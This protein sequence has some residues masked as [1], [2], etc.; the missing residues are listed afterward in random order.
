MRRCSKI[1]GMMRSKHKR[2]IMNGDTHVYPTFSLLVGLT[3]V[4]VIDRF[5]AHDKISTVCFN[6]R[7]YIYLTVLR[8]RNGF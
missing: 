2:C 1:N 3:N 8:N 5:G 6:N 7:K 4:I